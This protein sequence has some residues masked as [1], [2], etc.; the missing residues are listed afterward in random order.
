[1]EEVKEWCGLEEIVEQVGVVEW[2]RL[3]EWM[4]LMEWL[5]VDVFEGQDQLYRMKM[6]L[7]EGWKRRSG[8]G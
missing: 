7:V 6:E 8:C 5:K 1:M 3:K 2:M 4:W